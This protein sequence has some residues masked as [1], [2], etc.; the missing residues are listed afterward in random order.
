[1]KNIGED[2]KRILVHL[3]EISEESEPMVRSDQRIPMNPG[4]SL[5]SYLE[6]LENADTLR[7]SLRI[8]KI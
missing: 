6:L 5:R 7:D 4:K 1:M 2:A 8:L 3:E